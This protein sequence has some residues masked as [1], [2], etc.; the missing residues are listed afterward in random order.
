[1]KNETLIECTSVMPVKDP[2]MV[3]SRAVHHLSIPNKFAQF[4]AI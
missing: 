1:M 3:K 4:N 2:I